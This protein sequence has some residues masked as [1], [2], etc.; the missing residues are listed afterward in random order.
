MYGKRRFTRKSTSRRTGGTFGSGRSFALRKVGAKFVGKRRVA[1][2]LARR[3]IKYDDDYIN[4]VDWTGYGRQPSGTGS[5]FANFVLGG[6][7]KV[8]SSGV[9]VSGSLGG[10]PTSGLY[11]VF[12]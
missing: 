3:E 7:I 11:R 8:V 1:N 9:G 10:V 5:G 6:P 12:I 2:R 4:T